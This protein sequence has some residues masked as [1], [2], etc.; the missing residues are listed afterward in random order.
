MVGKAVAQL[1]WLAHAVLA[2]LASNA[3]GMLLQVPSD[4]NLHPW[5]AQTTCGTAPGESCVST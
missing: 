3:C 1:R 4:S 5:Y 2:A